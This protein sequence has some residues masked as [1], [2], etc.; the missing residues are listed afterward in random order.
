MSKNFNQKQ[1]SYFQIKEDIL[2]KINNKEFLPGESIP[3]ESDLSDEYGVSRFTVRAAL[4]ELQHDGLLYSVKG[5][6]VYVIGEAVSRDLDKLTGFTR[7]MK[8][9]NLDKMIELGIIEDIPE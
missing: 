6:G 7:S 8:K 1:A 4:L 5:K 2:E 9:L 3:P